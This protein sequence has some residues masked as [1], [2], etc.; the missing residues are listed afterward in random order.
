MRLLTTGRG[1][2][3]GVYVSVVCVCVCVCVC[4]WM[5][6]NVHIYMCATLGEFVCGSVCVFECVEGQF[7]HRSYSLAISFFSSAIFRL[8]LSWTAPPP[9]GNCRVISQCQVYCQPYLSRQVEQKP[10]VSFCSSVQEFPQNHHQ[11][12]FVKC[13]C[14]AEEE[15]MTENLMWAAAWC[16]K[17]FGCPSTVTLSEVC[18]FMVIDCLSLS[19]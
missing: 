14:K 13:F 19:W 7:L 1:V 8:W 11:R 17:S 2:C 4:V 6:L 16:W 15:N 18:L 10:G 5:H 12:P 3:L 9:P